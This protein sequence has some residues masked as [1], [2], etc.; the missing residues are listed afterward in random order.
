MKPPP[1][2]IDG[3]E[4]LPPDPPLQKQ[5]ALDVETRAT[6][7]R[8]AVQALGKVKPRTLLWLGGCVLAG[9]LIAIATTPKALP[10]HE[11]PKK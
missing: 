1:L 3:V 4:V 9:L 7:G 8:L 10:P 2:I 6:L 11:E 5:S